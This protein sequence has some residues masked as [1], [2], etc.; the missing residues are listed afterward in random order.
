MDFKDIKELIMTIDQ[1][2]INEVEIKEDDFKIR[3]SKEKQIV[4]QSNQTVTSTPFTQTASAPAQAAPAVRQSVDVSVS[5]DDK[6]AAEDENMFI[7]KSPIVGTFYS[8]PSPDS[9]NYVAVGSKVKS[10]EVVCIVEA[11][12]I[13]NEIKSE[14][15]GEV[16][17]ILVEN[18]DI[19][20][21]N[22]PLMI[23][24]R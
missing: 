18:E 3:I 19:V 9:E 8:S 15:D 16:Y 7:V 11:M 12:K 23:I 6:N 21:Y 14:V 4:V 24:R 20:E 13:M 22:Q 2:S 10:G 1:T 17:E 5:T